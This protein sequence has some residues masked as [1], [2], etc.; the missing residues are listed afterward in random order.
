MKILYVF[1]D[2]PQELNCS[3][4]N[5]FHPALAINKTGTHS[6]SCIHITEFIQN[7]EETQKLCAESDIIVV[8]RNL[9]QDALTLMMFWKVRGK[10]IA[11]IFDDAYHI[12]HPK[13]VSYA[14]WEHGEMQGKTPDG[15]DFIAY[16][17]P[18]PLVQLGW[19]IGM[20]KGLQTV[21]Q[22]LCDDW[23][24]INDTYLIHNH[25]IMEKYKNI[26]PLHPHENE[27]WIGWT[28]SLSHVDSFES[29]G[30]LR[31]YR[32]VLNKY[33]NVKVMISGDKRIYD[34]LDVPPYK[35]M[36]SSF[37]PEEQYA[38]LIKSI[39]IYTIPLAGEYDKRRSQIKPIECLALKI[40]FVASNFPNYNHLAP[41]GTF[42][43]NGW[44]N[45]EAAISDVIEHFPEYKQKS[46]EVG[47]PFALTQ[48]ID[49]HVQERIDLYQK[50]IDKPYKVG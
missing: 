1:A 16:M 31:A 5:C 24:H 50:M 43:E 42:T 10:A 3:K 30:L 14:F 44:Q 29:S 33:K 21:S 13:N 8:E 18:K 40:P 19:G 22:A 38:S 39:D 37:V 20:S 49:L 7:N 23:A 6:A 36:F 15:K 9:F 17:N 34:N 28:G 2:T 41:Y 46:E 47:Y 45:W 11:T 27:I 35:K 32:K 12:M 26:E 48:D 25:L 4:H